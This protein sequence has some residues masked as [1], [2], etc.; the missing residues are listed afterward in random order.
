MQLPFHPA[1]MSRYETGYL[2]F[3]NDDGYKLVESFTDAL[4]HEDTERD[5]DD[6]VSDAEGL[7]A[8][9]C[10]RRMA[11]ADNGH[12][13]DGEIEGTREFPLRPSLVRLALQDHHLD[14]LILVIADVVP[15]QQFAP[16]FCIARDSSMNHGYFFWL[17]LCRII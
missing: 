6:C 12:H 14:Q 9:G 8:D 15:S 13:D 1:R 5:A 17:H 2:E 3:A 11:V 10:R 16:H 4:E 7:A